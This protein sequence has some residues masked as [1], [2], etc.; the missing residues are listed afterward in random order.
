[1]ENISCIENEAS[2]GGVFH[3]DMSAVVVKHSAFSQ[4]SANGN[5]GV[6]FV[7][8]SSV[9]FEEVSSRSNTA[10]TGGSIYCRSSTIETSDSLLIS[11]SSAN[12]AVIY[13]LGSS[14]M[15]NGN[16]YD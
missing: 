12:I 16:L 13:L 3:I 9:K 4:N 14:A 11:N 15:F 2:E 5:G 6:F 10:Y 7:E 8:D 1:M